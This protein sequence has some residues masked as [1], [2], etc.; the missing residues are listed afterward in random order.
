LF[1]FFLHTGDLQPPLLAG[2][3]RFFDDAT[4][5]FLLLFLLGDGVMLV[6]ALNGRISRPAF[7]RP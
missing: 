2:V 4:D 7:V 1:F 5:L 3:L 6:I